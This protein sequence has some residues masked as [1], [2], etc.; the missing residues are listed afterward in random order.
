MRRRVRRRQCDRRNGKNLV[1][2]TGT[3]SRKRAR[4][5]VV[6]EGRS[7][8]VLNEEVEESRELSLW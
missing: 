6:H 3:E 8:G 7:I 4:Q 2:R 5:E 1:V